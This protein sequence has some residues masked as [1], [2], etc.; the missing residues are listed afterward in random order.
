MY[1]YMASQGFRSSLISN[2]IYVLLT[3]QAIGRM[4]LYFILLIKL[5]QTS[6]FALNAGQRAA[7]NQKSGAR[8]PGLLFSSAL[9]EM[10][11]AP[12]PIRRC[13]ETSHVEAKLRYGAQAVSES[14]FISFFSSPLQ[15]LLS[16]LS[17]PPSAR[18]LE[19]ELSL[20][21]N[22]SVASRLSGRI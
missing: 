4:F 7:F 19:S 14:D 9:L 21:I 16:R 5:T 10:N 17:S 6:E 22:S 2:N 11:V 13:I 20:P 8:Y 18:S 3:G 15:T 1:E 12:P